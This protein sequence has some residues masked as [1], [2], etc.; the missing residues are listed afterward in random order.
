M[1]TAT[2]GVQAAGSGS[3]VARAIGLTTVAT[4]I[5]YGI[6]L[7]QQL[8]YARAL[9]V[10]AD[11]DA[12]GAA[13][14]W[15]VST[16]GPL[17]A[18]LAAVFVPRFVRA[19]G[20]AEKSEALRSRATTIALASG[21]ILFVLT[22]AGAPTLA[23][24]LVPGG[25]DARRETLAGLLRIAAPLEITWPLVYVVVSSANAKER[26]L[27]AAGSGILPP[28]PVIFLMVT[29]APSVQA[30]AIAYVIGTMLQIGAVWLLEPSSRPAFVRHAVPTV[31][32][33]RDL[34]PVGIVF[35]INALIP[36]EV[37]GLASVHG[38]GAV[39]IADYGSRLVV[40]GQAVVLSGLIAVAFTRWSRPASDE[41]A[42]GIDS[43]QRTLVLVGLAGLTI[44]VVLPIASVP[45]IHVLFGGGK[46]SASDA[47]AVGS[48][49]TWMGPGIAAQMVLT[50]AIRA[51]FAVDRGS[52][53]ILASGGAVLAV[54][55]VGTATQTTW[56]LNGVAAAYSAG[57]GVAAV[58]AVLAIWTG[59]TIDQRDN[60]ARTPFPIQSPDATLL[61]INEDI[62]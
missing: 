19:T 43:V 59:R 60:V 3:S 4:A 52:P 9:G 24:I 16:T 50:V 11:T 53:L 39:A 8:L 7:L 54:L 6:T 14:A 22:L 45:V 33:A 13:L 2:G 41:R 40:A 48:F 61:A 44:A 42:D 10:S 20:D 55:V 25:D 27:L 46:F 28:I 23:G 30:V 15:A 58:I 37:R 29:G 56:G 57:Y 49:V 35:G 31:E 38:T 21:G 1:T 36:L 18:T 51:L 17:G 62:R 47:D 32:L 5:V 34:L 12:L 26:Y